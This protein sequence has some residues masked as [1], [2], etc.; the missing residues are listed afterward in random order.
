[1]ALIKC[2]E[3]GQNVSTSA[4]SCPHCGYPLRPAEQKPASYTHQTVKIRCFG[5][6]QDKLNEKLRPYTRPGWEIVS[7][8]EDHW[9]GGILS[10]VYKV[11]MKKAIWLDWYHSIISFIG[12]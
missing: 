6:G 1:M 11:I 9:Q 5:R 4:Y 2:P 10:P 7:V 3:C 12:S 8:V